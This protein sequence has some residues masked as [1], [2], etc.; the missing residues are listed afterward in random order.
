MDRRVV[1]VAGVLKDNLFESMERA[2][3]R[4]QI[5]MDF[6]EI[7]AWDFDF[8]ADSQ[9]GDRFRMLVEKVFT[10]R[11]V[12]QVRPD[13][14]GRVRERGT[15]SR[16]RVLQG[17]G[18][19]RLLHAEG[20]IAPAGVPEIAAGVHTDQLHLQPGATAPDPGRCPART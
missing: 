2:G 6:A 17:Q 9:P 13:S 11:P 3:E 10:G 20:R 19:E 16:R 5:V 18:R 1:L 12:C 14:G 4:P 8:A 15:G 7:F